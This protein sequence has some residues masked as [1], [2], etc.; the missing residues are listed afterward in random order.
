MSRRPAVVVVLIISVVALLPCP[1]AAQATPAA[2]AGGSILWLPRPAGRLAPDQETRGALSSSDYTA[3][4][5]VYL[6][7][8]ELEG[9]AGESIT[10]DLKSEDFDAVLYAVGPGL[11]ETLTDDDSGGRCDARL[12]IRFLEDG[13][14]RIAATTVSSRTTGVYTILATAN[15]APVAEIP[16]GGTDPAAFA[17]LPVVGQLTVGGTTGGSLGSGDATLEEQK[18]ADAWELTG[19]AGQ[20]VTIRLE[21]DS[22]DAFLVVVGPGLSSPV[23]DDDSAGELNALLTFT[24]PESGTYKVIATSTSSGATGAYRL[25]VGQ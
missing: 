19:E 15:P 24:F 1:A 6:D 8:W 25:S 20:T 23:T 5:D 14:F 22:Y 7:L 2:R 13:V 21:A 4:N 9:K 3:A 10:V 11:A 16:C 17:A 12:A 18:Y